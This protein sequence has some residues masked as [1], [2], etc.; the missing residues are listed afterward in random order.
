MSE[1]VFPIVKLESEGQFRLIGTGFFIAENG[2]FATAKHVLMDVFDEGDRQTHPISFI[3]FLPDNRYILRPVLRCTSNTIADVSVG[4][5]APGH[6][7]TTGAPLPNKIVTLT[8]V[9]PIPGARVATYGYPKTV[10]RE[11]ELHFFPAFYDG[12]MEEHFPDGRD[13]VT[14]SD[15]PSLVASPQCVPPRRELQRL[16]AR[17]ASAPFMG[18]S[19]FPDPSALQVLLDVLA[20]A[21]RFRDLSAGGRKHSVSVLALRC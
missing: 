10:A 5:A 9:P 2:V 20:G 6:H 4:V 8:V 16:V 18:F 17:G 3:Q 15:I 11:S 21:A 12:L 19:G 13:K 7:N 14:R 1:A